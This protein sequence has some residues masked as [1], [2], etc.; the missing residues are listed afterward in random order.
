M[1]EYSGRD[2]H[3]RVISAA[4]NLDIGTAGQRDPDAHQNIS[5]IDFRHGYRLYLQVFLAV[6][7]SSHHVVV[8]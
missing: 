1:T 6:K 8:H 5:R 2:D 3:P 4:E 7:H